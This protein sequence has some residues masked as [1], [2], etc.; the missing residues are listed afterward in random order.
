MSPAGVWYGET[1]NGIPSAATESEETAQRVWPPWQPWSNTEESWQTNEPRRL[2]ME[3]QRAA[4]MLL[5][6]ED[7]P[8]SQPPPPPQAEP[9][10]PPPPPPRPL[11]EVTPHL[12][13]ISRQPPVELA[14]H[15]QDVARQPNNIVLAVNRINAETTLN[16]AGTCTSKATVSSTAWMQGCPQVTSTVTTTVDGNTREETEELAAQVATAI[17]MGSSQGITQTVLA[18]RNL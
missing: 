15:L 3:A 4:E 12:Q 8:G 5:Y 6:T 2:A 17:A 9:V 11:T 1:T 16:A 10:P 14:P 13:D 7:F 18:W